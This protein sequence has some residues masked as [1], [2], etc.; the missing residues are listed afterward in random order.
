MILLQV[1]IADRAKQQRPARASPC[2]YR[3]DIRETVSIGWLAVRCGLSVGSA[4]HKLSCLRI[5]ISAGA[6]CL[7]QAVQVV[8]QV[9][10]AVRRSRLVQIWIR[11]AQAQIGLPLVGN[12]VVLRLRASGEIGYR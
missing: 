10:V 9:G 6:A 8:F 4:R 7:L 1:A 5:R 12:A 3:L 11:G 2:P